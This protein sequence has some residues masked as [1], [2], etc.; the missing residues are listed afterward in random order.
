MFMTVIL[1][2][3]ELKNKML[4]NLPWKLADI[5]SY[6]VGRDGL[7]EIRFLFPLA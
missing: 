1:K 5:F 6:G 4:W 7:R 2:Y 3:F